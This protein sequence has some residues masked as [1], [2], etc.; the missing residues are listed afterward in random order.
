MEALQAAK[1]VSASLDRAREDLV[2]ALEENERRRYEAEAQIRVLAAEESLRQAVEVL[3][4]PGSKRL[5]ALQTVAQSAP[6]PYTPPRG[7]SMEWLYNRGLVSKAPRRSW[8]DA[9]G[10]AL[11]EK[12]RRA[13]SMVGGPF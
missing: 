11:T 1:A 5:A 2:K 7:T 10:W 6:T 4:K 8:Y 13:L 3:K 9:Q 12:G